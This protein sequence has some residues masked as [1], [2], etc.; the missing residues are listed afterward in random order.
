MNFWNFM[1]IVHLLALM[2]VFAAM[3]IAG[4]SAAFPHVDLA[5]L[6]LLPWQ[7]DQNTLTHAVFPL[8]LTSHPPP[9]KSM[10]ASGP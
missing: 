9:R 7:S 2:V 5:P 1:E 6:G 8:L 3:L 10:T 4:Y